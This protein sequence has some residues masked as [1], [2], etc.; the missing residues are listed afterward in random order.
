[1]NSS[2][3]WPPR[4]RTARTSPSPSLRCRSPSRP[5]PILWSFRQRR[6]K[7]RGKL[8]LCQQHSQM[9]L[10]RWPKGFLS[11]ITPQCSYQKLIPY[12]QNW[13]LHLTSSIVVRNQPKLT[14]KFWLISHN[15]LWSEV[16]QSALLTRNISRFVWTIFRSA[17]HPSLDSPAILRPILSLTTRGVMLLVWASLSVV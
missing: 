3:G 1:M 12:K 4:A 14:E 7:T 16:K 8:S 11:T 17:T 13:L 2:L 5:G 10:M 6:G 9:Q 15:N